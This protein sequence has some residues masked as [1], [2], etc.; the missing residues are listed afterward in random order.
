MIVSAA[1]ALA[2][3]SMMALIAVE[4]AVKDIRAAK[5]AS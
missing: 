1:A 5:R 2:G 3:P 4:E